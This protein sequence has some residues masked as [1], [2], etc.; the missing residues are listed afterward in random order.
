MAQEDA[1]T[2]AEAAYCRRETERLELAAR[3]AS[4]AATA[5]HR[6]RG[7]V[8]LRRLPPS[9]PQH[10]RCLRAA[11]QNVKPEFFSSESP[12]GAVRVLDIYKVQS[13]CVNRF[14]RE[15]TFLR[16]NY[17]ESVRGHFWNSKRAKPETMQLFR[18]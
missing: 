14:T 7:S 11:T 5:E 17:L 10:A 15:L 18:F 16:I 12:Y 6:T 3:L 2:A 1:Q 9:H 13:N 8:V 4:L